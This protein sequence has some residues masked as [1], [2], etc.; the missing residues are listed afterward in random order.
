MR[1]HSR[2]PLRKI[3]C[4]TG[5]ALTFLAG[6]AG[7]TGNDGRL[8]LKIANEPT[9]FEPGQSQ[10]ITF[11]LRCAAPVELASIRLEGSGWLAT[12][13]DVPN[14][15]TVLP[16]ETLS[17]TFE[18]TTFT[19][20]S[21]LEL[22]FTRDGIER[23]LTLDLSRG[24]LTGE[25]AHAKL[26]RLDPSEVP[27]RKAPDP[28]AWS[29][30]VP[31]LRTYHQ[32]AP[33][34]K[35]LDEA[36]NDPTAKRRTIE[37][38]GYV[39]F[40]APNGDVVPAHGASAQI[41]DED[42]GFD[43][44]LG[45]V[46]IGT[47]GGFR[48]RVD[49][50]PQIGD[51]NP[52]IY[53]EVTSGNTAVT[54]RTYVFEWLYDWEGSTR[55]DFSGTFIDVE[56]MFLGGENK[57][58]L[59]SLK[60]LTRT[61]MWLEHLGY[62][63]IP[64]IPVFWPSL[65]STPH[66]EGPSWYNGNGQIFIPE[67]RTWRSATHIHEYGHHFVEWYGNRIPAN[68]C[69]S[70]WCNDEGWFEF[71]DDCG[72]CRWCEETDVVAFG[73]G[74]PNWMASVLAKLW[75]E[76]WGD[77]YGVKLGQERI[78]ECL[79]NNEIHNPWITEGHF[80][81][82]LLDIVDAN[83][84]N[85]EAYDKGI[86]ALEEDPEV[87]F[88]I[89]TSDKVYTPS[90]FI[91]KFRW[92]HPDLD[93]EFWMTL[94][95]NGYTGTDNTAPETG[96]I[97]S[98]SH[99]VHVA[100]PDN[101]IRFSWHPGEDDFSGVA[102]YAFEFSQDQSVAPGFAISED[103]HAGNFS[104]QAPPV[105]PGNYFFTLRAVD[106]AGNWDE[107][108]ERYGP[109]VIRPAEPGE[110]YP[111]AP[112]PGWAY[113]VVP[114]DDQ[115]ATDTSVPTDPSTLY[116]NTYWNASVTNVGEADINQHAS[117]VLVDGSWLESFSGW[118]AGNGT[119]DWRINQGP[120][121]MQ[122]GR[123][124]FEVYADWGEVYPEPDETN[125]R[126]GRQW[127][128]MPNLLLEGNVYARTSPPRST[129]GWESVTGQT[130]YYNCD[131]LRFIT[132][133]G[134]VPSPWATVVVLPEDKLDDL[135][136]RLHDYTTSSTSGFGGNLGWS[137]RPAQHVDAV[138][139]NA[140]N[141][142][143]IYYDAGVLNRTEHLGYDYEVQV[144]YAEPLALRTVLSDSMVAGE[145]L[146]IYSFDTSEVIPHVALLDSEIGAGGGTIYAAWY[147]EGFTTGK[148]LDYTAVAATPEEEG[149]LTLQFD[150]APGNH[151][152]VLWRDPIDDRYAQ[153]N[154]TLQVREAPT[155]LIPYQPEGW[156]AP[157][158]PRAAPDV[159][160]NSVPEPTLLLGDVA[161]TYPNF[162]FRNLGPTASEYFGIEFLVDR[163]EENI[164]YYDNINP[165]SWIKSYNT[166][167][168]ITVRGGRHV[169]AM[170]VDFADTQMEP[171]EGNNVYG[172]Q[173]VWQP[174]VAGIWSQIWRAE[175]PFPTADWERVTT[176]EVLYPN[177][178]GVRTQIFPEPGTTNGHWGGV[179]I[180]PGEFSD[181]DIK[182]FEMSTGARDGFSHPL[183]SSKWSTA[184]SDL[185]LMNFRNTPL[186]QFDV[187]LQM[188]IT[189]KVEDYFLYLTRS[190]WLGIDPES[191]FGPYSAGTNAPLL[192]FEARFDTPGLWRARLEI[193]DPALN[194]GFSLYGPDAVYVGKEDIYQETSAAFGQPAGVDEEFEF[195]VYP[196]RSGHFAIAVWREGYHDL[197]VPGSFSLHFER[198]PVID[199]PPP[200]HPTVSALR[201]IAPNPFNPST[202]VSFDLARPGRVR[203]EVYNVT[204]ARVRTLVDQVEAAG[205]HEIRWDGRDNTG[206]SVGSGVYF[207]VM[208]AEGV[209]ESRKISLIK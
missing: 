206:S 56:E 177:C 24:N 181:V 207:V 167:S 20:T 38:T 133:E 117:A 115:S 15:A 159:T 185:V 152:L 86:D 151:A 90:Q 119:H 41:W 163:V 55:D 118:I 92:R 71:L 31:Q 179:S 138:L 191:T 85:D 45:A 43:D 113:P 121:L 158:V 142:P 112:Y 35:A 153:R 169:M 73:E 149:A 22:K 34:R 79:E 110:L 123:H 157:L 194:L 166:A 190:S 188:G 67:D 162:C 125:N 27:T 135:E 83:N 81:A 30:S 186:R 96:E 184:Q 3:L 197:G 189:Q 141:R 193:H 76:E 199:A 97:F 33:N 80:G 1:I 11:E 201:Q 99:S 93:P 156:Y 128:W 14:Q 91:D 108:H 107:T 7:A 202:T 161:S 114:R 146:K 48:A 130:K 23:S 69:E 6:I 47:N 4:I 59:Q 61:R 10:A 75:Y 139:V 178:D 102:G 16:G 116:R 50:S 57:G 70:P 19:D 143:A 134:S 175:P 103:I 98:S 180:I 198:D 164:R 203:L 65:E 17:L 64:S 200:V 140:A 122:G 154:F 137:Q 39:Y 192:L 29:P 100:S 49:W 78:V 106:H 131:G 62:F 42:W 168:P 170:V 155:D 68:Y 2:I 171:N 82:L 9:P 145:G 208:E 58:A 52:D 127:I 13:V 12:P 46:M 21:P 150:P 104:W 173:Y 172:T 187:G 88:D 37:V 53:V 165:G 94:E 72:H 126:F 182:L 136:L 63:G 101:T 144:V 109:V 204:G 209:S 205:R 174:R 111:D 176:D 66:Y 54:V 95:N 87:V 148:L 183:A 40:R 105:A 120:H 132:L 28:M 195:L 32:D 8:D 74:F 5:I 26:E 60:S 89:V 36:D 129:G 160:S 84:D 44:P 51:S 196:T 18:L 124:T 77:Y 147:D 25:K